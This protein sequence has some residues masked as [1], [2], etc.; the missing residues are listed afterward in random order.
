MLEGFR[1][2]YGAFNA[3]YDR[4]AE[5]RIEE[6]KRLQL[7]LAKQK[8]KA[9]AARL[10]VSTWDGPIDARDKKF[11]EFVGRN[12]DKIIR[13]TGAIT[14][15]TSHPDKTSQTCAFGYALT[16]ADF[17]NKADVEGVTVLGG[18]EY[19][20]DCYW[21]SGEWRVSGFFTELEGS[22]HQGTVSIPFERVSDGVVLSQNPLL[23]PFK[24]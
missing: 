10:H 14:A 24:P 4:L 21:R 16:P 22:I 23:I 6:L 13:I 5:A 7:A 20:I 9:D 3:S 12:R 17:A 11:R 8:G 1:R 19:L 2:Q 18:I 15:P